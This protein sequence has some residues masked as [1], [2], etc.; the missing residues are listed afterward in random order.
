MNMYNVN[1]K[2]NLLIAS[3]IYFV[4]KNHFK[5]TISLTKRVTYHTIGTQ[6][7]LKI[8]IELLNS[9]SNLHFDNSLFTI[10][11]FQS[12]YLSNEVK[13]AFNATY[14]HIYSLN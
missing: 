2:L 10:H 11:C 12:N 9:K 5:I 3:V 13:F 8:S 1:R 7:V 14:D 4:E 6:G